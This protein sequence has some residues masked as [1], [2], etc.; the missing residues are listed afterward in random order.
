MQTPPLRTKD[1]VGA[2]LSPIF[3]MC[4]NWTG[5]LGIALT[6][7]SFLVLVVF[8]WEV[9]TH[10]YTNPYVGILGFLILPTLFVVGLVLI[11]IG[12]FRQRRLEKTS[13]AGGRK[14]F[15]LDWGNPNVRRTVFFV[16][17][18]T[19]INLPILA[20]ATYRGT[21]YL[22][23]VEF[24]GQ[25]C[26]RV[27]QPE[28]VAY[29]R[30]A[31]A[32]VECV[33]CHIGPGASWFVRSKLSGAYQVFATTF[34]LFPRPI[35][36]PIK[37]LRPARETCEQCHWPEKFTGDKLLVKTQFG[38]DEQNTRT[39][40]VLLMHIGGRRPDGRF[41]G[42]H[43]AHLDDGGRVTYIASDEKRQ[44][45]PWV[46]FR[47]QDGSLT[48]FLSEDAP[49]SKEFIA[50][51]D[52]RLMDCMDCHN[53]PTHVFRLPA[54]EIHRA[55]EAG[56]IDSELPGARKLAGELLKKKYADQ[57][58]AE[59][60][61]VNAWRDYYRSQYPDVYN[62][63]RTQVERA[64]S[65]LVEIYRTNVFPA[66]NIGW[67]T[68]PNNIGHMNFPGCFRCHDGSHTSSDGRTITQDCS[69][70]HGLL[71][72]EESNPEILE[73]LQVGF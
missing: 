42:I 2:W 9:L 16:F 58:E 62:A 68:Y 41:V 17:L 60:E 13:S 55:M 66:M 26:H 21:V 10:G 11:P 34:D 3:W 47:N 65:A 39:Q 4:Q 14:H 56:L 12:V 43:G 64:A 29:Q 53:R 48:E 40:T 1:L 37:N 72:M 15:V 7:A 57:A 32:R 30:S 28:F 22:G 31:H 52:K 8:W 50:Q 61:I 25:A 45:I 71:A 27:M 70:C 38:E 49:P 5:R 51:A 73:E 19:A 20:I 54:F 23:S 33:A 36:T 69:T 6:T 44:T 18:M 46:G 24:C 35:P 63:R 59:N 67:G